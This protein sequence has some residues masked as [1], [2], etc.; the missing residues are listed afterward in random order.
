M[1]SVKD[2][3]RKLARGEMSRRSFLEATTAMGISAALVP[4]LVKEAKAA[5]QKGGTLRQA[6]TGGGTGDVLDPAQTLDSY[7][8][9]VSFGQLRNCLTEIAPDGE[10]IG[11]VAESWEA[12]P[13]AKTWTFKIRQGIEFHNG[14]TLDAND[15]LESI[16][17]H[18]GEETKSAA[19][20]IIAPV[21]NAKADGKDT[22]VFELSGGNAD[23]PFL[24]SDY[25]LTILPAKAEG[26]VDWESGVGSG[27][28]VLKSFEPGQR[29]VVERNPNYWKSDR[30]YFDA[31]ENLYIAEVNS[32]T[33]AL[34]TG[35]IDLMTNVDL[36][37][38]HLFKRRPG[39]NV[40]HTTGNKHCTLPMNTTLAPFDN[41][42]LRM[43][44]KLSV[45]REQWR[46][47]ILKGYG[48]VGNDFPIGPAN[49]YR[50]TAD[51]IPQRAYD[52]EKAKHH[53]KKAGMDGA[54]IPL[55]VAE[56][57]FE[58]ALDAA[59]LLK[60]SAKAAGLDIDVVR[61]PNDGYWSNVWLKKPWVAS[62]WGGRPTEDWIFS[63]I[64]SAGADWNESFWDHEK[65]NQ[66]LV[67]ARAELDSDKRRA[68]YV[69]MQQICAN[70]G[71]VIIPLFMAYTHAASDKVGLPDT[72]ANNWELD[73]HKNAERWWFNS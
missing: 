38:V 3:Q 54:K 48:E 27:A 59:L 47:T 62:Y 46:D 49:R 4:A 33:N 2:L 34:Q 51:E 22:V 30:A 8:I 58:G 1:N 37:T 29:T 70:D 66:L 72:M 67:D 50:A 25:H 32:R 69:E 10:L 60:E 28:Y 40:F 57:A 24:M 35:E 68:M 14:K 13:D 39:I 65:F 15:V 16:N 61:E 31:I 56:T 63:Q 52:P 26:G 21:V 53:L 45:D 73:G 20:G 23:F 71:G 11:E 42:D 12:S 17:H 18:R 41:N 9:N 5:P 19:K 44:L 36:K 43:A 55:H 64:Y 6:I 7:M